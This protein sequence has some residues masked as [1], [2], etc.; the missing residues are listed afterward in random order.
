M[1]RKRRNVVPHLP[2]RVTARAGGGSALEVGGVVQSIWLPEDDTPASAD[3]GGYWDLM[4][5]PECPQ[6]ALLLGVGGG[7]IARALAQRCPTVRIVGIEYDPEVLRVAQADF[8]LDV[9]TQ[10]TVIQAD[11]FAWVAAAARHQAAESQQVASGGYDLICLDLFVA[12]R[13]ALGALA[14]PFLRQIA[15]LLAPDGTVSI[16]LMVTGRTP[17][18]LQRIRRVFSVRRELRLRGNLVVHATLPTPGETLDVVTTP[19]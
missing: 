15:S 9:I 16:N 6:S 12:G 8:G 7:T 5:P 4:L 19:Q 14:T 13:L 1:A 17:D 2:V 11:A 18:Q 10:L 3:R